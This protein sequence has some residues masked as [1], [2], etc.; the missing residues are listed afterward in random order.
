MREFT[1]LI[2][3]KFKLWRAFS[4]ICRTYYS[5]KINISIFALYD[6][7]QMRCIQLVKFYF[8]LQVALIVFKWH[9]IRDT[10]WYEKKQ[11]YFLLPPLLLCD[12]EEFVEGLLFQDLEE[13]YELVGGSSFC[14]LEERCES[15]G[16]F[17][18]LHL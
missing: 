5:F 1:S 4:A 15:V 13:Q 11:L 8:C 12:L 6:L 14:D 2:V 7:A 16:G 3:A 18:A 9:Y 17:N 10:G